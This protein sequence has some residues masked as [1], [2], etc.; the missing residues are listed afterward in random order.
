MTDEER[1][2]KKAKR[3]AAEGGAATAAGNDSN[4]GEKRSRPKMSLV[5]PKAPNPDASVRKWKEQ[6]REKAAAQA[7]EA[8]PQT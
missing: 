1:H 3:K 7:E 8:R 2:A 5:M 4:G 6:A